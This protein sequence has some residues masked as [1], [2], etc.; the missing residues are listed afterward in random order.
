MKEIPDF[1]DYFSDLTPADVAF[2]TKIYNKIGSQQFDYAVQ[3]GYNFAQAQEDGIS[4]EHIAAEIDQ[5]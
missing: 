4:V 2:L 1:N 3:I 5:L